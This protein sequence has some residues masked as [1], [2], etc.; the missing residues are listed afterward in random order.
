VSAMATVHPRL[1]RLDDAVADDS[2]ADDSVATLHPP[3]AW[4]RRAAARLVDAAVVFFVLWMLVVLRVLWFMGSLS[5]DVAP[6]PWGHAFV[7]TVAFVVLFVAYDAAY[8]A[9]N[10]GQTPGKELLKVRV[11]RRRADEGDELTD[12]GPVRALAR[13][14]LPALVWLASPVWL[15]F[16]L[17]FALGTSGPLSRRRAAWHDHLAETS[18]VHYD[19]RAEEEGENE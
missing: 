16:G 19:R 13:S 4:W 11:V 8:V 5:D 1:H 2:L 17:L 14:L 3:A 7:P 15:G 12:P 9:Y 18:V 10:R 6:E